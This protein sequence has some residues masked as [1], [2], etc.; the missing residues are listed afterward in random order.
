MRVSQLAVGMVTPLTVEVAG[1]QVAMHYNPGVYTPE[2]IAEITSDKGAQDADIL[3]KMLAS[4]ISDWDLT[5][6]D[7]DTGSEKPYPI[8]E[9][10]L[11]KLPVR[12]LSKIAQEIAAD[13]QPDPTKTGNSASGS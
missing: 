6:V 13:M 8:T 4:V 5:D 12:F 2:Y 3:P 11:R 1:G 10:N 7:P 9:A